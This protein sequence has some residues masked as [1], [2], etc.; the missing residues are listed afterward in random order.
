M[1]LKDKFR[2]YALDYA[3]RTAKRV[4]EKSREQIGE[5]ESEAKRRNYEFSDEQYDKLLNTCDRI[6]D[7]ENQANNYRDMAKRIRNRKDDRDEY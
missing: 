7:L 6:D 1:D 3:G 2:A 5:Y 4:V